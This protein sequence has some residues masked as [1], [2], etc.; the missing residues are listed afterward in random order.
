[1]SQTPADLIGCL[2]KG[3]RPTEGELLQTL[4][5]ACCPPRLVAV[6]EGCRWVRGARRVM[7][8]MLRHPACSVSFAVD[9][10]GRV[11]WVELLAVAR[12]PRASP[13]VR[14][15]AERRLCERVAEMSVGERVALARRAPRALF[16]LLIVDETPRTIGALLDNPLFCEAD[17]VRLVNL[18]PRLECVRVALGHSRWGRHP[19]VVHAALRL[20]N[21]PL[22]LAA[23][24]AVTLSEP[25]RRQ[26]EGSAETAPELREALHRLRTRRHAAGA[27]GC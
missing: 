26:L 27:R 19:A 17:A 2:E 8:M 5:S 16:A 15:L 24:L 4:R 22:A 25:Q 11:G 7:A 13:T 1:M 14:R 3:E 23:S 20:K 9:A 6:L 10:V 12:D 18:N 21:L